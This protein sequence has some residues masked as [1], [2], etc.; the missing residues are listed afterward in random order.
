MNCT[1]CVISEHKIIY[2]AR[3]GTKN[4]YNFSVTVVS[5]DSYIITQ[6]RHCIVHV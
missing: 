2:L 4:Y 3:Y 5:G 1:S 6:T